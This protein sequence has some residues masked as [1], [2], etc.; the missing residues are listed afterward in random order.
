MILKTLYNVET[1]V[2]IKCFQLLFTFLCCLRTVCSLSLYSRLEC[3][4][5]NNSYKK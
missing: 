1:F 4:V 3:G 5:R 2:T